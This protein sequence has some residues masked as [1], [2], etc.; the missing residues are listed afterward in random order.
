M[1][2]KFLFGINR[3]DSSWLHK[4][5]SPQHETQPQLRPSWFGWH[6]VNECV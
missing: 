2:A 1:I 6:G 4:S 5:R 3:F